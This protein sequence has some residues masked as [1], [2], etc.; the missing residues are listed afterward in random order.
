MTVHTT[1]PK[2]DAY[3]AKAKTW[4]EEMLRLREIV[5]D[6]G[7]DEDIKWGKPCYTSEGKNIVIFQPFKETCTLMLFKGA[8]LKD[9]KGVLSSQGEQSQSSRVMRF[10]SVGEVE[11]LASTLK[12]F[13][14]EAIAVEKA[15][16]KVELKNIEERP[17]PEELEQKFKAMPKLKKAFEALTPGRQRAYLM[18]FAAAKQAA[19]RAS[20][21]EKCVDRILAGKGMMDD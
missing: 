8:L 13:L 4:H 15:G 17:I 9:P 19:T 7:L 2:A 11:K 18:H 14:K 6:C 20:R 12:R 5:L 16:L 3:F 1:A 10:T 21:I